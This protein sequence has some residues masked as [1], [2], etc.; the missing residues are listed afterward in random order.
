MFFFGWVGTVLI[1]ATS[2]LAAP[3]VVEY[4]RTGVVPRFPTFILACTLAICGA[5][6]VVCG[7]ILASTKRYGD[8][9][10][11]IIMARDRRS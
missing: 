7:L 10:F 6:S 11:E 3:V 1:L 2:V 9:L 5:L 4:L 8:Q